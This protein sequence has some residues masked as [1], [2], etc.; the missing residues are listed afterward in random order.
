VSA[1]RCAMRLP[2]RLALPLQSCRAVSIAGRMRGFAAAR[3]QLRKVANSA[4]AAR[5]VCKLFSG[6][7]R[8]A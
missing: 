4:A 7:R 8:S 3:R 6:A 2:D 5:S 1:A